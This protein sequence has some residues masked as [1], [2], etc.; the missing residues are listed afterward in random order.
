MIDLLY[1]LSFFIIGIILFLI[2]KD[3]KKLKSD[4]YQ[5]IDKSIWIKLYLIMM[6][7]TIHF[8]WISYSIFLDYEDNNYIYAIPVYLI[9]TYIIFIAICIIYNKHQNNPTI[10]INKLLNYIFIIY[11]IMIIAFVCIP[12]TPKKEF[13]KY[14]NN[15]IHQYILDK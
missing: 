2:L 4:L 15:T 8:I 1:I 6:I 10:V 11:I 12:V 13:I 3:L 9:I 14:L 7:G 5:E